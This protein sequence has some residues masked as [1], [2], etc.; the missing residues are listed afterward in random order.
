MVTQT[1]WISASDQVM[2][3]EDD[4]AP[5]QPISQ[6][7]INFKQ[8]EVGDLNLINYK[9]ILKKFTPRTILEKYEKCTRRSKFKL[10]QTTENLEHVC[11]T[12][13]HTK[14]RSLATI[15]KDQESGLKAVFSA[16]QQLLTQIFPRIPI[17]VDLVKHVDAMEIIDVRLNLCIL[18]T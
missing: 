15:G 14:E 3:T 2:V 12:K 10:A 16:C 18:L 5:L 8:V 17:W 13:F 7:N 9:E 6:L 11:R 4:V 1:K